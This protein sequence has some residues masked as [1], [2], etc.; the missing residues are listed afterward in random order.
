MT[1]DSAIPSELLAL[2]RQCAEAAGLLDGLVRSERQPDAHRQP[3]VVR[4]ALVT[5]ALGRLEQAQANLRTSVA[6][7]MPLTTAGWQRYGLAVDRSI[8]IAIDQV[9]E[10]PDLVDAAAARSGSCRARDSAYDLVVVW[11]EAHP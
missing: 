2:Y 8:R 4:A 7:L 11:C 1:V 3:T 9:N 6:R 5:M 10:D